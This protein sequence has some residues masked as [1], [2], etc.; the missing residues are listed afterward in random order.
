MCQKARR[1]AGQITSAA[2]AVPPGAGSAGC[3][4][5]GR[6]HCFRPDDYDQP[7]LRRGHLIN[8]FS[9]TAENQQPLVD[10]LAAAT[11]E[12]MRHQ[13]GFVSASIHASGDGARVVNYAQW[14]S[15]EDFHAMPANPQAGEH[16]AG[17]AALAENF[18]PHLYRVASVHHA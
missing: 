17:C 10:L 1:D 18:E 8:V 12:V 11:D 5:D 14:A 2:P 4:D 13:R 16:M 15:E 7:R 9:V 6:T 3:W